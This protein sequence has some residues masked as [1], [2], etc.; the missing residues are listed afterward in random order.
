MVL[1]DKASW[2]AWFASKDTN[3][4]INQS[5]QSILFDHFND[6]VSD[7]SILNN[8]EN[9]TN[10]FFLFR[11]NFS[12][13]KVNIFHHLNRVGG[14]VTDSEVSY[15]FIQGLK[16]NMTSIMVLNINIL[17]LKAG[18]TPFGIPRVRHLLS[19]NK[20][21]NVK[22]LNLS[23]RQKFDARNFIPIPPFYLK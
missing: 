3:V 16:E 19:L 22:G 5:K 12:G 18:N 21:E 9:E 23:A 4:I 15:A 14:S 6:K 8:I 1:V 13:E 17:T 20:V 10:I 2:E 7:D 11:E